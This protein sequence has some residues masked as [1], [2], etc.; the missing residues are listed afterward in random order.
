MK[1]ITER[2]VPAKTIKAT[3]QKVTVITCD[4]IDCKE[5]ITSTGYGYRGSCSLC[6][7]DICRTHTTYDP[8]EPGDYPDNF[9]P[10]CVEIWIPMRREM[11]ER[12]WEEEERLEKQAR[13]LS[14]NEK[15]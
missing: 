4:A 13:K 5:K 2:K 10:K 1:K 3:T 6:K 15:E 14:L 8:D 7:R 12:H 9:C 11:N